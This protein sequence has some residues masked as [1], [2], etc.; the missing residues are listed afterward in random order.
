MTAPNPPAFP[1]TLRSK[2]EFP[3]A[4]PP[5][6]ITK[7]ALSVDASNTNAVEKSHTRENSTK[8]KK[9]NKKSQNITIKSP[10][11]GNL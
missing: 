9:N 3:R 8:Q 11:D 10:S 6:I 1:D 2:P 5:P 4:K 7:R